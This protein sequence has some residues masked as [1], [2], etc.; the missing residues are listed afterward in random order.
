MSS[1]VKISQFISIGSGSLGLNDIIPI[2][3]NTKNRTISIENLLGFIGS[4]SVAI[5]S[6]SFTK[7]TNIPVGLI[8]SSNQFSSSDNFTVGNISASVVVGNLN[9]TASY[10][11]YTTSA[12]YWS[13]SIINAASSSYSAFAISSSHAVLSDTSITA[14]YALNVPVANNSFTSSY[15]STSSFNSIT[16]SLS[17]L[18]SSFSVSSSIS[19]TSVSSSFSI[20]ASYALTASYAASALSASYTSITQTFSNS[21][22]YVLTASNAL[23]QQTASYANT[24]SVAHTASYVQSSSFSVSSISS[25]FATS[26]SYCSS[27]SYAS[28]SLYSTTSSFSFSPTIR[29]ILTIP[30]SSLLPAIVVGNI[31]GINSAGQLYPALANN[32]GYYA[33]LGIVESV[34]GNIFGPIISVVYSGR[35]NGLSGLS[36]GVLYYL[37][38]SISSYGG[39]TTTRPTNITSTVSPVL[40]STSTTSGIFIAGYNFA[41]NDPVGM[42]VSA[43]YASTSSISQFSMTC[44][45]ASYAISTSID[46]VGDTFFVT[47]SFSPGQAVNVYSGSFILAGMPNT[48]SNANVIGIV[49]SATTSS[50]SIVYSG[51]LTIPNFF[52]SSNLYYLSTVSSGSISNN[53]PSGSG[54]FI[55]TVAYGLNSNQAVVSISPNIPVNPVLSI[56]SISASALISPSGVFNTNFTLQSGS[57]GSSAGY[58]NIYVNG[59]NYKLA[60]Y[61]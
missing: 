45:T 41:N 8:S 6:I 4:A 2:V 18:T 38:D 46:T 28:T 12:S 19:E 43:S 27:A 44:V 22:S 37:S 9:G 23:S 15:L 3:H 56:S 10:S 1:Q 34:S 32:S 53:I 61:N 51:M 5:N 7:L 55:K 42:S 20:S 47:N 24:A 16:S 11:I 33:K 31:V 30:T 39:I 49:Q 59:G 13:G 40:V 21:G 29:E 17:V 58:V 14:S 35:I 36:P 57:V 54:E 60:L 25:S 48:S 26:A 52:T 50:V